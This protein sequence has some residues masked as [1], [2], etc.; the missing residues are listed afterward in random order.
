MPIDIDTVLAA[1]LPIRSG[2]W[3]EDKVILYHLGLGAGGKPTDTAE[4]GYVYERGLKVLPT[5][6]VIEA[7][8]SLLD[9]FNV[10]GFDV[11]LSQILHG[12]QELTIH[13]PL[14]PAAEVT[15]RAR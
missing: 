5:Y 13:A 11:K 14:P 6:G 2:G 15:T 9:L 8:Q 4:L 7:S 1:E 3:D 10:N 12:D